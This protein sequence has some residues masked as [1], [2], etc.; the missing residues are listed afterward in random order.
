MKKFILLIWLLA[1]SH[2][3]A[4]D[5]I[6]KEGKTIEARFQPP[7]GYE[8]LPVKSSSFAHYLRQL[9]L[10]VDGALV[11]YYNGQT[12]PRSFVYEAVVNLPIGKRNLHQC[13]DAVIRLRAEY[14]WK[15][16]RYDD[17][18]FHFTNGFLVEYA[19]W[20]EGR[21]VVIKGNKTYWNKRHAPLTSYKDFWRYLELVFS[22]AGTV[23]LSKEL[24][25][26][27]I[28]EMQIGDVFIV[29]G[30]P[31]HAVIVVDMAVNKNNQK[32]FMLAQS[33]MPAQEIQILRSTKDTGMN[34][35]YRLDFEGD[36]YT[37]EWVFSQ[38]SLKRF[39]D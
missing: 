37:P 14:L 38:Q 2:C 13:A 32:V 25:S 6:L 17:I 39:R 28:K 9:P 30:S 35:W 4:Q 21:R 31:G 26:V 5:L 19:K 33:Y 16:K 29:G 12:K 36:L 1:L 7:K 18:A 34:P 20:R 24:K 22:Y 10:K 15:Q 27:P 8:R 23:S 11:K 3:S